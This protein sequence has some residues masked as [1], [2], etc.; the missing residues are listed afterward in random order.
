MI[1]IIIIKWEGST[2]KQRKIFSAVFSAILVMFFLVG[3]G[4]PTLS[5]EQV[6][7][8]YTAR[9]YE[10]DKTLFKQFSEESGIKVNVIEGKAEEL[11]ERI[12]REG[13]N[14]LLIYSSL[15]MVES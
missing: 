1:I 11:I 6:V 10:V 13:E 7:N 2:L 8:V 9:N 4:S 3:C 14:S 5:T 15:L 12:K